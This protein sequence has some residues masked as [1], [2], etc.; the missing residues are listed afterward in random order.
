MYSILTVSN[1]ENEIERLNN[2]PKVISY[3]NGGVRNSYPGIL[4]LEFI[5]LTTMLLKV[6]VQSDLQSNLE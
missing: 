6:N 1:D 3:L 4:A 5:L 2:L